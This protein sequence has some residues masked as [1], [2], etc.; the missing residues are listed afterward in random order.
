MFASIFW[1]GKHVQRVVHTDNTVEFIEQD[2][3]TA[4]LNSNVISCIMLFISP[5][6]MV[7]DISS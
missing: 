1:H 2:P 6:T 5:I 7:G 4:V 3:R